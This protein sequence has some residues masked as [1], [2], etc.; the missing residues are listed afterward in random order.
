MK[1]GQVIRKYR[2]E[3]GLTQKEMANRLGVTTPAVN[4]WEK[5]S[6]NPD[7]ELLAPI[8]RLL[9][10]SLDTLMSFHEELSTTE[11][12]ELIHQLD[13]MLEI[14]EYEN[15]FAWAKDK[16]KEYPNCNMLIWQMAVV[17][18]ARRRMNG[19]AEAEKYD[20]QINAWYEIALQDANEEIKRH[21]AD[22]LFSFYL[23]KKEYD[24]AKEYLSY[25][26]EHDANRKI[27]EARLYKEQGDT[28]KA[29][30]VFEKILYQEYQTINLALAFL[31]RAALEEKDFERAESLAEKMG[32]VAH[33]FEMGKYNEVSAMLDVMCAKKDVDGTYHIVEQ[34]LNNVDTLYDF[35]K[36]SLFRHMKFG[37]PNK[38]MTDKLKKELVEG[39]QDEE[40]FSYMKENP[41]WEKLLEEYK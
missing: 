7:I 11:I 5:G 28:E 10:I 33:T 20:N 25:F 4:K 2:I 30:E 41:D 35:R 3:A 1:I 8:A 18:D 9:H 40:M 21:A 6:S 29:Y 23:R 26:S 27:N 13:A 24:K 17:L 32:E 22:S 15:A 37:S 34:L 39:F 12:N 38:G 19:V 14:E 31:M 36:S 16:I